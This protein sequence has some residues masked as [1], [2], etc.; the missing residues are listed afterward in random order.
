MA[1]Q[2]TS[3][4]G[5][6][7]IQAAE[8]TLRDLAPVQGQAIQASWAMALAVDGRFAADFYA[9]LFASAPQVVA[10]FPGDMSDQ[11]ERLTHTLGEC[12]ALVDD[13]EALLL[14]LKASGA[15]HQYYG[16]EH[17]HFAVM[18]QA[19]LATLAARLGEAF[20]PPM[21][22]AWG[23]FF[24]AMAVIMRAAMVNRGLQG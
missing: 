5:K 13:P 18:R 15:R 7:E 20:E 8:D 21:Q 24:D 6:A 12:V 1:K 16:T 22:Q 11:Q 2:A 17:A 3:R 14:L 9:Q 4:L 10:L 19:L 23:A